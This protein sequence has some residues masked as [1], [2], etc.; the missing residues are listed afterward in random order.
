MLCFVFTIRQ[1]T[2]FFGESDAHM[3]GWMD[4]IA[5]HVQAAWRS[6]YR[7]QRSFRSERLRADPAPYISKGMRYRVMSPSRNE[8]GRTS[9]VPHACTF[10][11]PSR[12]P[13]FLAQ[14]AQGSSIV[15]SK[16][17]CFSAV[18]GLVGVLDLVVVWCSLA[19]DFGNL[20]GRLCT[21]SQQ[22]P[23]A[24]RMGTS[25]PKRVVLEGFSEF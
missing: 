11:R 23:S 25:A 8:R 21:L 12:S 13:T 22:S 20:S 16:R 14:S 10:H 3:E 7:G 18:R 9:H 5:V 2:S 6:S 1:C 17:F 4:L 19:V 24:C 15:G